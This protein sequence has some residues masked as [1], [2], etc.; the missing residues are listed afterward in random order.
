MDWIEQGRL[1][2]NIASFILLYVISSLTAM[3]PSAEDLTKF[4]VLIMYFAFF[5][6]NLISIFI[7]ACKVIIGSY[8]LSKGWYIFVLPIAF[9]CHTDWNI[10]HS[11]ID[12]TERAFACCPCGSW[13]KCFLFPR[14]NL[15]TVRSGR[16]LTID[17]SNDIQGCKVHHSHR[18]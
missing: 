11:D 7:P 16:A 12:L 4:W 13:C 15:E 3:H 6:F 18:S 8:P 1:S 10:L 5:S 17:F 9:V 14:K 2:L